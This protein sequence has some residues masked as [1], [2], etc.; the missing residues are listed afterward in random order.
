M[1]KVIPGTF[2]RVSLRD[3]LIALKAASD[4]K[5]RAE[6]ALRKSGPIG[7]ESAR[8]RSRSSLVRR[9]IAWKGFP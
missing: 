5:L 6:E 4:E 2:T 8:I 7:L 3:R 9:E 1:D